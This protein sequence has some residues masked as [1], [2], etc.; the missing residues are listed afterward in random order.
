MV[1][2]LFK[3]MGGSQGSNFKSIIYNNYIKDCFHLQTQFGSLVHNNGNT[4]PYDLD[5][6]V[7]IVSEQHFKVQKYIYGEF[8][9]NKDVNIMLKYVLKP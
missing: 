9:N 3:G 6:T 2:V 7:G 8:Q 4:D 1:H 5:L